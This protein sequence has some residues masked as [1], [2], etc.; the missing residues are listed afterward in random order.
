VDSRFGGYGVARGVSHINGEIA[1]LL[2]GLD[3]SDQ[4]NV[5]NTLLDL[6]GTKNKSRIGG[7]TIVAVS[8]AVAKAAATALQQP[9]YK[10]LGGES[11]TLLPLPEIQIFG[12]GAHAGRRVD[13]Q[14]FMV[15][16]LH[17][18]SFREA[19]EVAA[20]AQS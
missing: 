17:A 18:Q 15:V 14:D 19:L 13:I 11:A 12:G 9:L 3:S 8:M 1:K 16:A 2:V 5:D 4:A 10:Y 20:T 7:N 6:D